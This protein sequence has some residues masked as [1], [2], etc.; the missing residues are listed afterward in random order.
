MDHKKA[1]VTIEQ[2]ERALHS[3]IQREILGVQVTT[4]LW[5][6]K[7]PMKAS[8]IRDFMVDALEHDSLVNS[9]FD[10]PSNK[11]APFLFD[12]GS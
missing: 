4:D 12:L 10:T 11:I 5:D 6:L 8:R 9:T 3:A 7:R 1:Y 2:A